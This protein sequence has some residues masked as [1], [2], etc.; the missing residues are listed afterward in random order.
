MPYQGILKPE[1]KGKI[2]TPD[3]VY[4]MLGIL[5]IID[6][7]LNFDVSCVAI[8]FSFLVAY[9]IIVCL[10]IDGTLDLVKCFPCGMWNKYDTWQ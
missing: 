5:F 4:L 2:S 3:P 6:F 1:A 10:S 9:K 7:C 8:F